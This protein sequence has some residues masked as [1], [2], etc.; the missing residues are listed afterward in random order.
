MLGNVIYSGALE[1]LSLH[2]INQKVKYYGCFLFSTY[3]VIVRAKKSTVYEPKHW[4]PL[5]QFTL[6]NLHEDEG[7]L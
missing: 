4:F 7:M 2:H 3:I 1:M 6:Q 5:R